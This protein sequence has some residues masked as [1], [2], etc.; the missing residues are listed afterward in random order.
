MD[1]VRR[2]LPPRAGGHLRR[3]RPRPAAAPVRRRDAARLGRRAGR[4]GRTSRRAAG[5]RR[6]APGRRA[7]QRRRRRLRPHAR[8]RPWSPTTP[9][10]PR[11]GCGPT[12]RA[13]RSTGGRGS[14]PAG[15]WCTWPTS[16]RDVRGA[17]EAGIDVIRLRRP[18]HRLDPSG[19]AAAPEAG[20]PAGTAPRCWRRE[21]VAG[22]AQ[23][24]GRRPHQER[25]ARALGVTLG[26]GCG[27]A[28][29]RPPVRQR[30]RVQHVDP[31]ARA[32]GRRPAAPVRSAAASSRCTGSAQRWKARLNVA[33]WIGS[34]TPAAEVA[35]RA[36]RLLRV[37][38][39]GVPGVVV[40]ADR[41][42]GQVE[43][44]RAGRRSRRRPGCSRCRRRRRPGAAG[45]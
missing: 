1:P 30:R 3:P 25:A 26:A 23:Q 6:R 32:G 44:A 7:V 12:S 24:P 42:Q 43:R 33:Q 36:D 35:V 22:E 19:P 20:G 39:D 10:S 13:R 29:R 18:G 38:V 15:S 4:C 14:G 21:S 41:Q 37:H 17:L 28:D 8:W 2:A 27:R 31:L 45:R 5:D 16:A 40:G 34:S 11:S 9:S